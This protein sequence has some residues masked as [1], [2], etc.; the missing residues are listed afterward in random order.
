MPN[1]L[2]DVQNLVN[3]IRSLRNRGVRRL[4]IRFDINL[5]RV[6]VACR[7]MWASCPKTRSH[8]LPPTYQILNPHVPSHY[9]THHKFYP[10]FFKFRIVSE[11]IEKTPRTYTTRLC[12]RFLFR[13][14]PNQKQIQRPLC[15]GEGHPS[16]TGNWRA[17]G[18]T[19]LG[20]TWW[21]SGNVYRIVSYGRRIA[22]CSSDEA[23]LKIWDAASPGVLKVTLR[24]EEDGGWL[25]LVYSSD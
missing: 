9:A 7:H 8:L 3:R 19:T 18:W 1:M 14:R 25:C 21:F 10:S 15:T 2:L 20:C 5:K 22:S 16:R 24:S 17:A 12:I 11:S 4:Q 13:Q 23:L 6:V